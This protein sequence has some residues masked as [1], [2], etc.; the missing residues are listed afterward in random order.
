MKSTTQRLIILVTLVVFAGLLQMAFAQGM[1]QGMRM[2]PKERAEALGKQ[3]VLDSVAVAKVT[4]VMEKY[5]KIMMDKRNELQ[6]D[7]EGMRAAM[8]EVREKQTKEIKGL[9][10]EE[11][12]KKYDEILKEQMQRM[13]SRQP[14]NN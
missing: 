13:Q 5:Q 1:G 7:M 11:Q 14:R 10:T 8:M 12:A 9:L 3:L 4:V 2:S 6:G